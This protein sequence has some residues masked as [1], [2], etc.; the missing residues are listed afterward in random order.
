MSHH[1]CRVIQSITHLLIATAK[2]MDTIGLPHCEDRLHKT[3]TVDEVAGPAA[4]LK[5]KE[6]DSADIH[7]RQNSTGSCMR[8]TNA[9]TANGGSDGQILC[10]SSDTDAEIGALG[11]P[12]FES[13]TS[14]SAAVYVTQ[15]FRSTEVASC[16]AVRS[17]GVPVRR[18]ESQS[19][20]ESRTGR[21]SCR[22]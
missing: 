16:D 10:A 6:L 18:H 13:S 7:Q 2:W 15:V 1:R 9:G 8:H 21:S 5:A 3:K 12:E 11:S 20:R 4:R 19:G 17:Y 22:R 14:P